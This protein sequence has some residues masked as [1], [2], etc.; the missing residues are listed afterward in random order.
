MLR[1]IKVKPWMLHNQYENKS[2]L[3]N[4]LITIALNA[5]Y[6]YYTT[7]VISR[8][9][10]KVWIMP[11]GERCVIIPIDYFSAYDIL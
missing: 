11:L 9:S 3:N 1:S 10:T 4:K 7:T 8:S 2:L 6:V 5:S